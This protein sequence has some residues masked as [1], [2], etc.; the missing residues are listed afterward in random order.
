[1]KFTR[2]T[3]TILKRHDAF[4]RE[5]TDL[6]AGLTVAGTIPWHLL[7]P[8]Q[9]EAWLET[10]L[11]QGLTAGDAERRLRTDGPNQVPEPL[12]PSPWRLFFRQFADFMVVLLCVA[13]LISSLIGDELDA[14]AIVVIV[15]INAGLGF[16]QEFRAQ[17]A[18][19]SLKQLSRS[20]SEV[21]RGGALYRVPIEELVPGDLIRL[22]AGV[23][24]PADLRL[25]KVSRLEI[26]E[27]ILTGESLPVEKCEK[28]LLAPRLPLMEQMNRAFQGT[29]VTSGRGEGVVVATGSHTEFGR[30]RALMADVPLEVTPLQRRLAR[31]GRRLTALIVL[32]C[33]L[34]FAL[35]LFQGQSPALMAMTAISLGVAAIPEALPVV[36][37]VALALGA[38]HMARRK[39]LVRR[40]HAVET[41][42]SVSTICTDK[43]GTL[44]ENRMRAERVFA[45][46]QTISADEKRPPESLLEA[47][48]LN[49]DALFSG[50]EAAVSGDPTE[51]ALLELASRS[52]I[53]VDVL[54]HAHP[55]LAEWPFEASSKRMTT[56]HAKP[57][58]GALLLSKGAPESIL[59][60]CAG[61]LDEPTRVRIEAAAHA[62]AR[63]GMRVI[64]FAERSFTE[65]P[66][67]DQAADSGLVFMGLVGLVDPP[68]PEAK[69]AILTCLSAGIRPLMMTGD[70]P[71]TARAIAVRIGLSTADARVMT[72][73][74]VDRLDDEGLSLALESCQVFARM[75]PLQKNRIVQRLKAQGECVAM[76][77]DGANDAPALK[78]ADIGLAMGLRG[79]DVAKEAASLILLDDHFATLVNAIEEGRRIDDNIRKFL[80]Y[81]LTCNTAEVLSLLLAPLLGLPLPLLPLQILWINLVTDGLPGLALAL[82]PCE[83]GVMERKPVPP[84]EGLF[85]RG[86][87][88]RV[89]V[90]GGVMAALVL[91]LEW[92][93]LELED[94]AWQT[95]VFMVLSLSQM[96]YVLAIRQG[97]AFAL[98]RGFFSNPG[99]LIGVGLTLVL[100][101]STLY[102]PWFQAVLETRPLTLPQVLSCL[103]LSLV[104]FIAVE[105]EKVLL[106]LSARRF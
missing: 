31:L 54:R 41:L 40:L 27:S 9:L 39:T 7:E 15:L 37:T 78:S 26:D 88:A 86:L 62:M 87:G 43:T 93:A 101:F 106:R 105:M 23:V 104:I 67:A 65:I 45:H 3:A 102:L 33:L 84:G 73:E 56:L 99:L 60:Q 42:G 72:G 18:M 16:V 29:R 50:G 22:E 89:M 80:R 91:G 75:V 64:A 83:Q 53:E 74:E 49:N 66:S 48:V 90:Y 30:I 97:R 21:R 36:A 58:G 1:M 69:E 17:Q 63:E 70:H 71:E 34:V 14:L 46:N 51:V 12:P 79:T 8:P 6:T 13:A 19:D 5:A 92:G 25:V 82:E 98:G 2:S 57:K 47:L 81:A 76:T 44:T 85:G 61:S 68:R 52:G 94:P 55:R 96:T 38:A 4:R 100:Q 11:T 20:T 77:G 95:Q 32:I 35:G 24:I 10:D 59:A 28:A 103:G